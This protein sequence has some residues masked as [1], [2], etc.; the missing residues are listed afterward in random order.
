MTNTNRLIILKALDLLVM[1]LLAVLFS[2][3][4]MRELAGFGT[5]R[6]LALG[7][8]IFRL[9]GVAGDGDVDCE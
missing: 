8:S 9:C 6:G 7:I 2:D 3:A 4:D 5:L 1:L